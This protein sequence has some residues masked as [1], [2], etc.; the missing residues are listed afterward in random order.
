MCGKGKGGK[1]KGGKDGAKFGSKGGK[2]GAGGKGSRNADGVS[3]GSKH[4][5]ATPALPS[6]LGTAAPPANEDIGEEEAELQRQMAELGL[7]VCF[8]ATEART[9][10]SDDSEDDG[11]SEG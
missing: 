5:Q 3:V 8:T 4:M 6:T 9:D 1:G 11:V 7:P 10:E 2:A